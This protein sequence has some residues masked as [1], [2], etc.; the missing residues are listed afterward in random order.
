MESLQPGR[1]VWDEV[2]MFVANLYGDSVTVNVITGVTAMEALTVNSCAGEPDDRLNML[3][4]VFPIRCCVEKPEVRM[5]C[6][7]GGR[8]NDLA[9]PGKQPLPARD[10]GGRMVLM[11]P[12]PDASPEQTVT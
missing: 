11:R 1:S 5:S 12:P 8:P 2:S 7:K 9:F 6:R 4:M 3:H 10:S